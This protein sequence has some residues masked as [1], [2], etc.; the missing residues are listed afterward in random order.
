MT[1]LPL[2]SPTVFPAQNV[3]TPQRKLEAQA[4]T[5]TIPSEH[6]RCELAI[7]E[8]SSIIFE[9]LRCSVGIY[10]KIWRKKL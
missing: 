7:S 6:R 5:L 3:C 8:P 4:S 2:I 10:H 1:S 9:C